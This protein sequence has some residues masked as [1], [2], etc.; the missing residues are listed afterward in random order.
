[1]EQTIR[2]LINYVCKREKRRKPIPICL[3]RM[4]KEYLVKYRK[5]ILY[6]FKYLGSNTYNWETSWC[7]FYGNDFQILTSI[8]G[9]I[10][11]YGKIFLKVRINVGQS[12]CIDVFPNQGIYTINNIQNE[13]YIIKNKGNQEWKYFQRHMTI[14]V[15]MKRSTKCKCTQQSNENII[16]IILMDGERK[17]DISANMDCWNKFMIEP[18]L[19]KHN[20]GMAT[21]KLDQDFDYE[22]NEDVTIEYEMNENTNILKCT[23]EMSLFPISDAA[24]GW[25]C[26]D[27][28]F[29]SV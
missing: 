26:C 18:K 9:G 20:W 8:L 15:F 2:D 27:A 3:K 12:V 17:L 4:I 10:I 13:K 24:Q 6:N 19:R 11:L 25:V 16:Q 7:N 5:E 14:W 22:F 28:A 1:M 23:S 21:I 29:K